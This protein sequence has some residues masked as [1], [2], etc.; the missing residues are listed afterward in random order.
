MARWT[1]ANSVMGPLG[2]QRTVKPSDGSEASD[3]FDT[4]SD[5][6]NRNQE[7]LGNMCIVDTL[8]VQ[9]SVQKG[10]AERN[11]LD[12][13][14]CGSGAGAGLLFFTQAMKRFPMGPG[15][16]LARRR[17]TFKTRRQCSVPAP[18][19]CSHTTHADWQATPYES[20]QAAAFQCALSSHPVDAV[21]I[22]GAVRLMKQ[23]SR[24]GRTRVLVSNSSCLC[25]RAACTWLPAR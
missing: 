3:A 17:A 14:Q 19:G 22:D 5:D 11:R 6:E 16:W 7:M 21:A 12:P 23:T 24:Y 18:P 9:P 20:F 15:D 10:D 13:F 25:N 4:A 8:I 2:E 1:V